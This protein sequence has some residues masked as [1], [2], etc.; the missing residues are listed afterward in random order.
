MGSSRFDQGGSDPNRQ[1]LDT[2]VQWPNGTEVR[3]ESGSEILLT[4]REI[5]DM[6]SKTLDMDNNDVA[7]EA[8]STRQ[9]KYRHTGL[10]I[11]F[12]LEYSNRE[13]GQ[14]ITGTPRNVDAFAN[15]SI[16]SSGTWS[17]VGPSTFYPTYPMGATGRRTYHRVIRYPQD[18]E[19]SFLSRGYAYAYG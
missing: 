17:S 5:L 12:A 15:V 14:I 2:K 6:V 18:I 16:T 8:G 4:V 7:P 13:E 19:I 10:A 9:P 3:Y 11:S 1:A